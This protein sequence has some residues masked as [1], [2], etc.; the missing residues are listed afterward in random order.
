MTRGILLNI[1]LFNFITCRHIK[2]RK[3]NAKHL[4]KCIR[5]KNV[6]CGADRKKSIATSSLQAFGFGK[7]HQHGVGGYGYGFDREG[8]L[9]LWDCSSLR[10]GLHR[11]HALK[12][13]KQKSLVKNQLLRRKL[14]RGFFFFFK[15][16]RQRFLSHVFSSL[17]ISHVI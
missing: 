9:L 4:L 5:K 3:C 15:L 2:N 10:G 12:V 8:D 13:N 11:C 16:S 14:F 1:F 7:Q 17:F 6:K